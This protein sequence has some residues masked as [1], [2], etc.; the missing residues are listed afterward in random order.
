MRVCISVFGEQV[1]VF[2]A[3]N[4]QNRK[5]KTRASRFCLMVVLMVNV[6]LYTY[7]FLLETVVGAITQW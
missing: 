6:M 1:A 5:A 2:T 7:S 3:Y 4:S